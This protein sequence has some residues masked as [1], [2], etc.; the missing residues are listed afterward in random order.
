MFCIDDNSREQENRRSS[1]MS[2]LNARESDVS[3]AVLS[4]VILQAF[5]RI[6]YD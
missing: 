4:P 6:N 5:D 1:T 2:Q 3:G